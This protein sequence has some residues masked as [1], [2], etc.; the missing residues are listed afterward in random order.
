[1]T[2]TILWIDDDPDIRRLAAISLRETAGWTVVEAPTTRDATKLV[3]ARRLDAIVIDGS[4]LAGG[5]RASLRRVRSVPEWADVPVVL[6]GVGTRLDLR[7][8][9]VPEFLP[10]PFDPL[11][12]ASELRHR[13]PRLAGGAR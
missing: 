5:V 9:G 1:M 3:G 10:K 2:S 6:S 13:V 11:D 7:E 8:L 12:L 4:L